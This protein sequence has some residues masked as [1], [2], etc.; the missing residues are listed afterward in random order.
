[1]KKVLFF[2][3]LSGFVFGQNI[4]LKKIDSL[5]F[6]DSKNQILLSTSKKFKEIDKGEYNEKLY[7][8]YQN[9]D[10]NNEIFYIFYVIRNEGEN[11]DL[12]RKGLRLWTIE[13]IAGEYPTIFS[14]Y[15]KYF[16]SKADMEKIQKMGM[17]WNAPQNSG[18]QIRK[19]SMKNLWEIR[20]W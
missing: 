20:F 6:L 15:K 14:F 2:L 7:F 16:N 5:K 17:D 1:M 18:G 4:E 13:N 12:K 3:V 10:D 9:E 19:T 11:V 8:K